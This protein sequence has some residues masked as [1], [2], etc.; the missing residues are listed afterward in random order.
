MSNQSG[1]E[2]KVPG[3]S[4]SLLLI[5]D[6]DDQLM[7]LA[8]FLQQRGYG[9]HTAHSAAEGLEILD[10]ENVDCAICDVM[11]PRF[12]GRDFVSA[13]RKH[14]RHSKLPIVM[15]TAAR[16]DI[17]NELLALGAN[18]FCLKRNVRDTLLPTLES[19]L[20]K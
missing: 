8:T 10:R 13:V 19:L 17:A 7:V 2:T 6:D 12:G 16:D 9:V 14:V 11:M 3:K 5:D 1:Q 20:R 4:C 15:L 18:E